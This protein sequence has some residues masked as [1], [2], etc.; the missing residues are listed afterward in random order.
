M[1]LEVRDLW[2]AAAGIRGVSFTLGAEILG[3][4]ASSDRVARNWR[5]RC[6]V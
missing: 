5:R 4:A 1:C 2:S 3:L 6:S